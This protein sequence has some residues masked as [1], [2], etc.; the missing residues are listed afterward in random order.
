MATKKPEEKSHGDTI[1]QEQ[2]GNIGKDE[3][4]VEEDAPEEFDI[5]SLVGCDLLSPREKKL[6]RA[7]RLRPNSYST[8]K[9][10]LM[11]DHLDRR[12][13]IPIKTCYQYGLDKTLR[14]RI[15]NF[16]VSCGWITA[17]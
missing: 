3:R 9:T 5:A 1:T 2:T 14:K 15:I 16:M 6:C 7:L 12:Q 8:L 10:V 13:G 17:P 11:R 4:T